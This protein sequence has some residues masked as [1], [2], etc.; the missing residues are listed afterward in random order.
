MIQ[1]EYELI[2]EQIN[3]NTTYDYVDDRIESKIN[4]DYFYSDI[5]FK[6]L[7]INIQY[8]FMLFLVKNIMYYDI[9][10]KFITQIYD[11]YIPIEILNLTLQNLSANETN[12]ILIYYSEYLTFEDYQ[13]LI[14]YSEYLTFE[15][16][17]Q[18]LYYNKFLYYSLY[19][20]NNELQTKI[21]ELYRFLT[22]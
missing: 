21:D 7:S 11:N 3:N 14:Y 5:K 4:S 19:I 17:Q 20:T 10:A 16:Y 1:K 8:D 2:V 18:L 15:D 6:K 12:N 22:I 9:F 13:Q